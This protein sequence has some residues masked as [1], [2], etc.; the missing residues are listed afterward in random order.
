MTAR[1]VCVLALPSRHEAEWR[2]ALREAARV[3]GW[4]YRDLWGL[5]DLPIDPERSTVVVTME[6]TTLGEMLPTDWVVLA[7]APQEVLARSKAQYALDDRAALGHA[8]SR[9]TAAS[10][11]VAKGARLH[12]ASE[13]VLEIPGLGLITRQPGQASADMPTVPDDAVSTLQI[14]RHLPPADGSSAV[15][16]SS[17]FLRFDDEAPGA[18]AR[19]IDLTG[20]GRILIHGPYLALPAG[21]WRVTFE[22]EYDC[23]V[24]SAPFRFEWG[25][26][27]DVVLHD[28]RAFTPGRY[29][30]TLEKDWA[31]P[32]RAEVRI[33]LYHA[34]FQGEF[35]LVH[36]VVEKVSA[37][38]IENSGDD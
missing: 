19:S 35:R 11:L 23:P 33:W 20:R 24:G 7:A 16:P 36:C 13:A 37:A 1:L 4:D 34:L 28:A 2:V 5:G 32:G 21:R 17:I 18:A 25:E 9:L 15:W 8:A 31:E 3:A 10:T 38:D 26:V 14:F 6:E 12:Q 22:F 30:I 27:A 29:S